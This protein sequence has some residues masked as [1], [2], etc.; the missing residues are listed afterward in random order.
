[1]KK[2][3]KVNFSLYEAEIPKIKKESDLLNDSILFYQ[4]LLNKKLKKT[5]KIDSTSLKEDTLN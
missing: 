4:E 5:K 2:L 1:M 3:S